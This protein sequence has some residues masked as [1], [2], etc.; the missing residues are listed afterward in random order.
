[1]AGSHELTGDLKAE[2]RLAPVMS[3]VVTSKR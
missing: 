2:P 1:M 3:V